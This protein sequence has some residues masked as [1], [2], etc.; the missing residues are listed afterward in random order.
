[1]A[2]QAS[3][4]VIKTPGGLPTPGIWRAVSTHSD[5]RLTVEFRKLCKDDDLSR[6]KQFLSHQGEIEEPPLNPYTSSPRFD[7][8]DG[9]HEAVRSGSVKVVRH[10]ISKG[11]SITSHRFRGNIIRIAIEGA[12]SSG[13]TEM[14]DLFVEQGW[15]PKRSRFFNLEDDLDPTL[16]Q[17]YS[18]MP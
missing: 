5:H 3:S 2:L 13:Q 9:F 1:M 11:F 10:S 17:Q 7:P 6:I 4:S 15:D 14:L 8:Y 12:T 16:R 18:L